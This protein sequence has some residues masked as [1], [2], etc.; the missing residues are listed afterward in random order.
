MSFK[1][2]HWRKLRNLFS[3]NIK[4][5]LKVSSNG[6]QIWSRVNIWV[7]ILH[8]QVSRFN[9]ST[10]EIR[11]KID[12]EILSR[13]LKWAVLKC[14]RKYR[15]LSFLTVHFDSNGH[16]IRTFNLKVLSDFEFWWSSNYKSSIWSKVDGLSVIILKS[17]VN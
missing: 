17:F 3:E 1:I 9:F 6:T 4:W 13:R 2:T 8:F 7:I 5:N 14:G 12:F 11:T 15:L 10:V 16:P